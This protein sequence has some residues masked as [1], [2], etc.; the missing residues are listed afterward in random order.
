ME[1][2]ELQIYTTTGK[3]NKEYKNIVLKTKVDKATGEVRQGLKT[4]HF[5]TVEKAFADGR[6][7]AGGADWTMFGC[8]AKYKGEEV[9]FVLYDRDHDAWKECGGVGDVI[10]ISAYTH[11]YKYQDVEK[12]T[13]K[14]KFELVE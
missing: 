1:E 11:K 5:I 6:K 12:S 3:D 14:L 7:V 13:L 4:D 8:G 9:S 10:R 2:Q